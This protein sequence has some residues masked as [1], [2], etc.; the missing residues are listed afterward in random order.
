MPMIAVSKAVYHSK[1]NNLND[2]TL[3]VKILVKNNNGECTE[4]ARTKS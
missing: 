3:N 4:R 2:F 1:R